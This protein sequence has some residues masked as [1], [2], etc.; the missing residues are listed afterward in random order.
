MQYIINTKGQVIYSASKAGWFDNGQG[1][2]FVQVNGKF[3]FIDTSGKI[4]IPCIYDSVGHFENDAAIVMKDGKYGLI[5]KVGKVLVPLQFNEYDAVPL[6]HDGKVC[7]NIGNDDN[8]EY[9][10]VDLNGNLLFTQKA[11]VPFEFSEGFATVWL[12]YEKG[13]CVIDQNGN[14]VIPAGKYDYVS[15]FRLGVAEVTK[16]SKRGFIN[17]QG[18]VMVP[19]EYNSFYGDA[20]PI[21]AAYI[22]DKHG[23]IDVRNGNVILPVSIN[24]KDDYASRFMS[25]DNMVLIDLGEHKYFYNLDNCT[26]IDCSKYKDVFAFSEGLCAVTDRKTGKLGFIDMKGNLAIPCVFDEPL[27]C[28]SFHGGTCAMG[29]SF[30]NKQGK[31]L[32]SIPRGNK[33]SFERGCYVWRNYSYPNVEKL[34]DLNGEV[35]YSGFKIESLGSEFP[36]AV[37]KENK[38][39]NEKWGFIDKNGRL[40]IPYQ[41]NETYIFHDG[42]ATIDEPIRNASRSSSSG[43]RP[44]TSSSSNG[45]CY[46]ATAV[47]GSYDCPE[48][49]TLRRY[50]DNTLDRTLFGRLFIRLYYLVSPSMVKW[51]GRSMWFKSILRRPL[52]RFVNRLLSNG[53]ENTPYTDKY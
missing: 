11:L 47:Y 42:F 41:F 3:G 53:V 29:N 12:S 49:W 28:Y 46:I 44:T 43:S 13:Y 26:L 22:G 37:K 5:N 36:V 31:V 6:P 45:G 25:Y 40:V 21:Q 19:I 7:Y 23:Y 24:S 20:F 14:I 35:K 17:I 38:T 30:I 18:E 15:S 52:D 50:R 4:V 27:C 32:F 10:C 9:C 8:R 48:V 51:F 33:I 16:G 1:R 2:C 39:G 34:L